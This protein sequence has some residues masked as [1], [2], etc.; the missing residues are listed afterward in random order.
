[1]LKTPWPL[2]VQRTNIFIC[3]STGFTCVYNTNCFVTFSLWLFPNRNIWSRVG[4]SKCSPGKFKNAE[5]KCWF[6]RQISFLLHC[7]AALNQTCPQKN[8]CPG[9]P[10]W[11]NF[12]TLDRGS[13]L[14]IQELILCFCDL[15][16]QKE[17]T[18]LTQTLH[19]WLAALW[20]LQPQSSD[21]ISQSFL[22]PA[23]SAASCSDVLHLSLTWYFPPFQPTLVCTRMEKSKPQFQCGNRENLEFATHRTWGETLYCW[24]DNTFVAGLFFAFS[25][26]NIS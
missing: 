7:H 1:M 5:A 10:H 8:P 17:D 22:T 3:W 16:L 21:G 13:T 6:W 4:L 9:I 12:R 2:A 14:A 11:C 19:S 24:E 26:V 23:S 25:F 20:L 15:C 18:T